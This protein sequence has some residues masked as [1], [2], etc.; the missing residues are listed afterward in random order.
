MPKVLLVDD[1]LPLVRMYQVAF[2]GS[3]INIVSAIDGEEA[4]QKAKKEN[5]DLILLDLV[6]P[7]KN[8]FDVLKELKANSQ[9]S[10][11][12]VFCLTVLHQKEDI[13]KCLSM[14]AKDY[15]VKT[16]VMP[17]EVISRVVGAL[18]PGTAKANKKDKLTPK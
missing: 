6:L 3:G 15:L 10:Q 11:I 17:E 13:D 14:G 4:I 12:P 7:K 5:P 1:D 9:T 2:Q 18:S 16:E 8:G